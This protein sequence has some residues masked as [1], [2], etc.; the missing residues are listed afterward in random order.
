M[1]KL[2]FSL[3][4]VLAIAFTSC[5][6]IT[7]DIDIDNDMNPEFVIPPYSKA[8]TTFKIEKLGIENN[9]EE[10]LKA[11][12]LSLDNIKEVTLEGVKLTV[13]IPSTD[14]F[15]FLKNVSL[16]VNAPGL[17]EL[18]IAGLDNVPANS[19]TIELETPAGVN[20]IDYIK[21]PT[22]DVVFSG[23]SKEAVT[24]STRIEAEIKYTVKAGL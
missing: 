3:F 7:P 15:S 10:E 17:T 1:K 2:L 14:D 23:A 22:L 21:S 11:N 20:L 5:D 8:D 6:E 18:E 16:S 19:E 4:A 9:I 24:D 13:M 12:S